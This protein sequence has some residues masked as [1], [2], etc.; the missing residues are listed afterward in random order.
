[1]AIRSSL[2][3]YQPCSR[4]FR[5]TKGVPELPEVETVVRS[6]APLITGKTILSAALLSHR[7]TRQDHASTAQSLTGA[8]IQHVRRRG[9]Q[10]LIDLD[11]GLLYIHLGMTGKLL[12]STAAE[13]STAPAPR[14]VRA[15]L[16]FDGG[17]LLYDDPRM[18]GRVE[19]YP[20]LPEFLTRVGPDA[21][22]VAAD[23][24]IAQLSHHRGRIKSVLLN[25]RFLGGVGN[26]YAD[27]LLFAARVHPIAQ[28]SRLSKPRMLR[29]HTH[30]LEILEQAVLHKGSSISDYVDSSGNR[31]SFQQHHNVY[32]RAG[33]PCPR[34][35]TTIRRIVV[36]Q[37]GTHY[38]PRCQRA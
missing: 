27:E 36:A 19:F 8:T 6:V 29:L 7:V 20:T 13:T 32:G 12:W 31:G 24:F 16:H 37:R 38:C 9:K 28:V 17:A 22:T 11:R 4:R 34:C 21:L 14:H 10:I 5:H 18:F 2:L 23:D 26:I 1:M 30:L 15:V 35:G 3:A 33:L 25:Q